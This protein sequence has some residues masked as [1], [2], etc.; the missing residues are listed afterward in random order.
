M[1]L[2][3]VQLSVEIDEAKQSKLMSELSSTVAGALGKP[4]SYMMVVL[5]QR[6]PMLLGA[7]SDPTALVEIRSVG[8]ISGDQARDLSG[9]V[10]E[11]IGGA[12]GIGAD[13]IYSNF[14]GVPGAMWGHNGATFG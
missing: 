1:P 12:A 3:R 2:I 10:S 13:R 5:E 11:V 14:E 4:E 7:S 6:T 8:S 9:K